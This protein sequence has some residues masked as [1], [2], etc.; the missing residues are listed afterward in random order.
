[1][2][3]DKSIVYRLIRLW[4][5]GDPVALAQRMKS[6]TPPGNDF[7]CISL[8]TYV[9]DNSVPGRV[10]YAVQR[11]RELHRPEIGCK[12]AAGAGNAF[13]FKTAQ[14]FAECFQF[15]SAQSLD[16]CRRIDILYY[17]QIIPLK[18]PPQR[19]YFSLTE[20]ASA[21]L[22]KNA[23]SSNASQRIFFANSVSSL[24]VFSQPSLPISS[25]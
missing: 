21:S 6:I 15:S 8:M 25:I 18:T 24:T 19:F 4:E 5:A 11:K 12:V 1:M 2:T 20:S 16:I 22:H 7:V 9:K 3:G 10:I 14:L 13:N 23:V 17:T